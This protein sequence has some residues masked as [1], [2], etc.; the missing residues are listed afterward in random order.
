MVLMGVP[1]L[2]PPLDPDAALVRECQAGDA[3]A[4]SGLVSRHR[5]G[6]YSFVRHV[7]GH[8]ADAEDLAQEAFIRAYSALGRFRKGAP[9]QP[10]LYTIAANLCRTHLRRSRRRPLSLEEGAADV[11]APASDPADTVERREEQRRVLAAIRSLPVEQR[12][13]VVLRH[14]HG[15]SYQE[16]SAVVGLPVSTVEHR[17][18]AARKLLR[19]CLADA[20]PVREEGVR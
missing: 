10:W 17:L 1:A 13:I 8:E 18:R 15:Y 3:K 11:E 2:S 5:D 20:V 12:M 7:I 16:I 14:L 6:V 9:F 4:F 19:E